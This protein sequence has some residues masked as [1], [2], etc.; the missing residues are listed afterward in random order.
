MARLVENTK[1]AQKTERR[2]RPKSH[3]LDARPL[4]PQYSSKALSR[5]L[6]ILESFPDQGTRLSLK[7]ISQCNGLPEASLFR[8][9]QVLEW[10]GYLMQD[11][12][13]TYRLTPR[14]LYGKVRENAEKLRG[15]ARPHL[16]HLANRFNET[17]SL[18]YLFEDRIQ[19]VDTVETFHSMRLTNRPGRV[20]PPH[21]SS[22]GKSITAFQAPERIDRMLEVYGLFKRGP[23]TILDRCVLLAEY[24]GIRQRGYSFDREEAAPGGFCIGAPVH[25]PGGSVVAATSLSM[26]LVRYQ[27][28]MEP[29]M[30]AGVRETADAIGR[31]LIA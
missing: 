14:V 28:E 1:Q 24:E 31:S 17:A 5:A 21:C 8:I 29:L 18:A 9:L 13:G 23:N 10:R 2:R 25:A 30:I 16:Q 4:P 20:L 26:P 11:V 6:D 22:M 19:V 15:L 12:D 27:P 3:A 7:E